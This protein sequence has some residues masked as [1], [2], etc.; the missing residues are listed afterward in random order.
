METVELLLDGF[1]SIVSDPTIL[2][3]AVVGCLVGT[4]VGLIP[5]LGPS[6]TIALLIPLVFVLQPEQTLVMMVAI[7]LGAEFGGRVAAILL[8]IPGDA[9]AIMTTLDGHP[10]ARQGRAGPALVVSALSSFVGGT[11]AVVG[12]TFLALPLASVALAF[13]PAE[14]FAVVVM[15]LLLSATLVGRS[16]PKGAMAILLGLAVATVGTDLQTGVPRFTF[17]Q[18]FLLEGINLIVPILGLYGVAEILWN[19]AHPQQATEER[20]Q[21]RGYRWPDR[22]DRR[23]SRGPV[24]RSSLVGFFAGVLPGSGTTLGSFLAYSIEKRISKTPDRFGKGA[25]EGVA[26]PEAGNNAAVGGSMVPMMTLGIPGSGTT[27]ILLAYLVSYGLQPGPGFF[28]ENPDLAWSIVASLYVSV[29]ALVVLNIPLI[30]L[31]VRILDV[32]KHYLYPLIITVAL[33]SG[34]SLNSSLYDAALVL[35][36]G[37]VGYGMRLVGM[38]PTL[39][40]IALV[41]GEMMERDL[42]QALLLHNGDLAATLTEPL[43]LVFL[44][45]GAGIVVADG[46][47]SLRRRRGADHTEKTES[48]VGRS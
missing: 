3:A 16:V 40:I 36:F 9:G 45:L 7:Y 6:T 37:L 33:I 22:N 47:R 30:P 25:V 35:I 13:G 38:S 29:L 10:M 18:S 17:G 11:L 20:A 46:L 24:A 1:A 28:S 48:T 32:P 19:M 26:A 39:F 21:I 12:L 27:A 43:A 44:L 31:F 14:Y 42:R 8:N 5:G 2:L 4:V 23:R 15:A 41:L 34:Y